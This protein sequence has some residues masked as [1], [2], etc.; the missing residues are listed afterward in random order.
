MTQLE[1]EEE[2]RRR[3]KK[4]EERRERGQNEKEKGD[5]KQKK[6]Q[7]TSHHHVRLLA[8]CMH[9]KCCELLKLWTPQD[10]LA[11]RTT[12]QDTR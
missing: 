2:E 7:K 5:E 8:D 12:R 11:L 1:R 6:K 3:K 9:V 4:D 10:N